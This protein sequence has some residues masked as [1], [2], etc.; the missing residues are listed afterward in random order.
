MYT[1]EVNTF[2]DEYMWYNKWIIIKVKQKREEVD[3]EI[4]FLSSGV[5]REQTYINWN[6]AIES[7]QNLINM[8]PV[9]NV[10]TPLKRVKVIKEKKEK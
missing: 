2:N 6:I 9:K 10:K 5:K 8:I 1:L 7:I 4:E 3:T